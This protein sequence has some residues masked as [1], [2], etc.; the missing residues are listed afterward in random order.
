MRAIAGLDLQNSG[1]VAVRLNDLEATG[2]TSSKVAPVMQK[3]RTSGAAD[4]STPK[5]LARHPESAR[6]TIPLED[7]THRREFY[8]EAYGMPGKPLNDNDFQGKFRA[9]LEYANITCGKFDLA[10]TANFPRAAN[11]FGQIDTHQSVVAIDKTRQVG[12]KSSETSGVN[13][14]PCH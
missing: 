5:A 4:L 12:M 9:C 3:A 1:R 11:L 6:V 10:D 7:R 14:H 8:G 13:A 2:I